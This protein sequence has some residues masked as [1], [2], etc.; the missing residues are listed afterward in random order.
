MRRLG[1]FRRSFDDAQL[2]KRGEDDS[3]GPA[4]LRLENLDHRDLGP[5]QLQDAA[6]RTSRRI[7][8]ALGQLDD[9]KGSDL[10][11]Y[12]HG[13][14]F[15]LRG[16]VGSYQS[17]RGTLEGVMPGKDYEGAA[18]VEYE[19]GSHFAGNAE[20][21]AIANFLDRGIESRFCD[22]SPNQLP[23]TGPYS[24]DSFPF[25][26]MPSCPKNPIQLGLL[27]PGIC[28][29]GKRVPDSRWPLHRSDARDRD[30]TRVRLESILRATYRSRLEQDR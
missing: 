3:L 12:R 16:G 1:A 24:E 11:S 10:V 8:Y 21:R 2:V 5:I 23:V 7:V 28:R 13:I 20:R 4:E 25:G 19:S 9:V 30:F 15:M 29:M 6:T 18:A 17:W 14:F 26:A 22:C 27:V